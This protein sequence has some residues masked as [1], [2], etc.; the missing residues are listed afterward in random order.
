M[1]DFYRY[2]EVPGL[3]H[4]FGGNGGRPKHVFES[5]QIWVEDGVAPDSIPIDVPR[6]GEVQRWFLCP[7]P[8]KIRISTTGDAEAGESIGFYCSDLP[9]EKITYHG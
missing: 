3:C 9:T 2:F 6:Q 7:Y 4:C 8:Q 5:L 1:R